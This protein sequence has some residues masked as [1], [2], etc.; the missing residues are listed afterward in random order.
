MLID[1]VG[2][3]SAIVLILT[4]SRQVYTQ[5]RTKCS[6]GVSHWL[7]IGQVIASSGFVIYSILVKNWVFVIANVF[8]LA[9]AV[10]GQC[11]YLHNKRIASANN[12]LPSKPSKHI[13]STS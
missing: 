8:I 12:S 6:T 10:V 3:F 4:I 11:I 1:M 7:F 13:S 2:W 9:T 5:W